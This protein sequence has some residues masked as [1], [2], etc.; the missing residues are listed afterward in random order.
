VQQNRMLD[1]DW[2]KRARLAGAIL[3]AAPPVFVEADILCV[4][5]MPQLTGNDNPF[6]LNNPSFI[7][8]IPFL[9]FSLKHDLDRG[10]VA[11]SIALVSLCSYTE[12]RIVN[13]RRE[14]NQS[15]IK[16]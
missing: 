3:V 15:L 12:R 13:S 10:E 9:H 16:Q 2:N 5:L 7:L 8:N 14:K 1:S 11:Y 4:K 6:K